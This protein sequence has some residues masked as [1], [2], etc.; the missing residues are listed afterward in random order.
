MI[1]LPFRSVH[2]QAA[3]FD[4]AA[5]PDFQRFCLRVMVGVALPGS[6]LAE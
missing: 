2:L 6:R 5:G 3:V 1:V 4:M